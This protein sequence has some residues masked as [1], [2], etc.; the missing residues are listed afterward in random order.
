VS[1]HMWLPSTTASTPHLVFTDQ[2]QRPTLAEVRDRLC[3]DDA[4]MER[5]VVP[6]DRAPRIDRA[7]TTDDEQTVKFVGHAA[8][9]D[10][11]SEDL[12]LFTPIFE[13]IKRGAFK[14]AIKN[15]DVRFR[16]LDHEGLPLARSNHGE[17]TLTLSEDPTGLLTETD[18]DLRQ[19][20]VNDLV[21]ALERGDITQMSFAFRMG[22]GS[23]QTW[24]EDD[25]GTMVRTIHKI[26]EL[27]D[28]SPVTF[29]AYPDT[30]AGVTRSAS[31]AAPSGVEQV[32]AADAE[33]REHQA[34]P[35]TERAGDTKEPD[36]EPW[37]AASRRRRL[38]QREL[39]IR[40]Q[41]KET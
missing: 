13:V 38:K 39:L 8:V 18:L 7:A 37:R 2:R 31:I 27:F 21:I 6:F 23:E 41:R 9:F 24:T 3:G 1:Q 17:G 10:K 35:D 4:P 19:H 28:V 33:E 26:G 11:R 32:P 5:R 16:S 14:D 34:T 25:D 29:P 20:V 12:G 40:T 22:A 15:S 30:D 36:D